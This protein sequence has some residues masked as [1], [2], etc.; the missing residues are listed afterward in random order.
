ML[1]IVKW[2]YNGALWDGLGDDPAGPSRCVIDAQGVADSRL[3]R[4]GTG[5]FARM[6]RHVRRTLEGSD[7]VADL[8]RSGGG[9]LNR[10]GGRLHAGGCRSLARVGGR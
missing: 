10:H 7:N 9:W 4:F 2:H 5:R 6:P 3:G 8:P 1:G